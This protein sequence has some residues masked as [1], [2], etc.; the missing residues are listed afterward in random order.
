MWGTLVFPGPLRHL[1]IFSTREFG[2]EFVDPQLHHVMDFLFSLLKAF[3]Y[4]QSQCSDFGPQIRSVQKLFP[5]WGG[6]ECVLL[7]GPCRQ[8]LSAGVMPYSLMGGR[9]ASGRGALVVWA[10][11]KK[12]NYRQTIIAKQFSHNFRASGFKSGSKGGAFSQ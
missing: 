2:R 7:S 9:H 4:S 10:H 3:S 5:S 8:A 1:M 6:V 11:C 12:G